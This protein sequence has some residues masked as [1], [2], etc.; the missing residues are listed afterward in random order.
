MPEYTIMCYNIE[1]MNKMF[2]NNTVKEEQRDRAKK[3]GAII[4]KIN[5]SILGICEAANSPEEHKHFI[6][7]YLSNSNYKLAHGISR[8]AQNLVFYYQ[9]PFSV[10]SVDNDIS[11]Y[12]PWE[13]DIDEDGLKERYKWD[14]IPLEVVFK[15]NGGQ[16]LRVIL[17]HAKSKGV[18]SVVDLYNYQKIALANRKRLVSQ[19]I[20][21][22]C[23]GFCVQS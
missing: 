21:G 11:F 3:I 16:K 9:D 6:E 4:E 17:V 8:G 14:R 23:Y 1:H 22:D 19:W 7:T 13:D 5:P 12:K 2:E 15:T 10:I 20:H 18:F